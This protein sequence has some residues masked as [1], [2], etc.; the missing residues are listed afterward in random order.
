[1]REW[2]L[3]GEKCF[4]RLS[5]WLGRGGSLSPIAAFSPAWSGRSRPTPTKATSPS[6]AADD[7]GGRRSC[8][9]LTQL[10][11][12]E[13]YL[14]EYIPYNTFRVE[15]HL[16]LDPS[17][18]H[19]S[20]SQLILIMCYTE[21]VRTWPFCDQLSSAHV[22]AP[23]DS[24]FRRDTHAGTKD[25]VAES[26]SWNLWWVLKQRGFSISVGNTQKQVFHFSIPPSKMRTVT[27]GLKRANEAN[28]SPMS[29]FITSS[30]WL[31]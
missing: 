18:L 12:S 16:H 24:P 7:N 28:V 30:G 17:F 25:S 9:A 27:C 31:F 15:A 4:H 21:K 22:S 20:G 14:N 2:H 26:T 19:P 13:Y 5:R 29:M 23:L 11:A 6:D 10:A 3:E 8:D 1:M